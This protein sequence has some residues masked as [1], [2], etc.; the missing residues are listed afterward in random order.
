MYKFL[1]RTLM[2]ALTRTDIHTDILMKTQTG[3]L[4]CTYTQ[5]HAHTQLVL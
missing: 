2:H 3:V 1:N 5:T 4:T